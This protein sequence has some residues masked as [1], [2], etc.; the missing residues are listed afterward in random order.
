M[1]SALARRLALFLAGAT[2]LGLVSGAALAKDALI[3]PDA[4]REMTTGKTL[5]YY[6]DGELYGKEYY[7][8][9]DDNTVVF[10]FPNG[11]CAEGRWGHSE[12][13]FC[14]AF[15]DQLH[16]FWH[17]MRDGEIVV[18]GEEDGEEQT[19]ETIA[20]HEPIGCGSAI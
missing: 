19:V 10:R 18:I 5:H 13:K 2:A 12:G 3:G 1:T 14:F 9:G 11:L 16:C 8:G 15:G 20:D 4:W 6:K 17:V 7:P